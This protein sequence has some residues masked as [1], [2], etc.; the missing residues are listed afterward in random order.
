METD[1]LSLQPILDSLSLLTEDV[2]VIKEEIT[3]DPRLFLTTPFEEYTVT[4]GLILAVLL[5]L[6]VS[7]LVRIIKE[8]FYWLL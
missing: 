7:A 1:E 2:S 4:E 5:C 8:G 3:E 6:F